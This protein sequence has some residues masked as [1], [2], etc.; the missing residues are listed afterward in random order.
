MSGSH[1]G[2]GVGYS[3]YESRR[4]AQSKPRPDTNHVK[5]RMVSVL[6]MMARFN[7]WRSNVDA[8]KLQDPGHVQSGNCVYGCPVYIAKVKPG[9]AARY[10]ACGGA[11]M[12]A[13]E[14]LIKSVYMLFPSG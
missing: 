4:N 9:D 10:P 7:A 2:D 5:P 13:S 3:E 11:V 1:H 12:S 6:M 14:S 8:A